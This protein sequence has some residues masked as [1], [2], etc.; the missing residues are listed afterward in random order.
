MNAGEGR[1]LVLVYT[2]DGKGKTTAAFGLALRTV[3]H[4][5]RAFVI[6]FMKGD[7][8]YGELLAVRRFLAGRVEVVQSG[9]PT[10]VDRRSPSIDD[11]RLAREGMELAAKVINEGR[12]ELVILDEIN[13]A[14]D[15]GLVELDEVLRLLAGRPPGIDVV[16]T[17]RYA[18]PALL[19][20]ADLVSEVA[21]VKHP[22]RRGAAAR[23]GM[24]F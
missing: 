8:D 9:L 14:L 6:Q 1:G 11:R 10:F 7:P 22:F 19:E 15:Y 2:G 16:L 3:G 21:E 13:V 24:E 12:Y 18:P 23:K 20:A 5:G 4:G 17:G